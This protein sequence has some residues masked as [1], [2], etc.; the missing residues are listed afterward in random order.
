MTE[1]P[2]ASVQRFSSRVDY[3][4]RFRPH[5]PIALPQH[6]AQAAGLRKDSTVADVGSGT[7]FLSEV[8]LQHGCTV[9]GVEPNPEMR[10]AAEALLAGYP[11]FHSVEGTAEATGLPDASMDWV[12][13][14]QA[15]HWFDAAAARAEFLRILRPT[16][17]A[18]IVWNDRNAD[19]SDFMRAYDALLREHAPEYKDVGHRKIGTVDYERFF[20][21]SNYRL[22]TFPN[23]QRF[24]RA[25]LHGRLLSSSYAPA[26]GQP[27]HEAMLA[28]LD[29][30]FDAHQQ[31]GQVAFTY[32]T[33]VYW[34]RPQ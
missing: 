34:G 33:K 8:F 17:Q 16:G 11:R 31:G 25:G 5:Y 24:D 22:G 29:A 3:Y 26:P 21:H 14:G 30:L 20:G 6:L 2:R 19:G 9:H 32:V 28:A 12:V 1:S 4:V 18:A 15:F 23:S 10:A 13:A 7:G 27:G